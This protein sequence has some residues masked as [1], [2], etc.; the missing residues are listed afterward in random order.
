M[1]T[2]LD[3]SLQ[4]ALTNEGVSFRDLRQAVRLTSAGYL[5]RNSR[6]S[7]ARIAHDVG[8]FDAAHFCRAWRAAGGVPPSLYRHWCAAGPEPG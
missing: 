1:S 8:F 2:D 4:R 7:M 6:D 3:G 5:L